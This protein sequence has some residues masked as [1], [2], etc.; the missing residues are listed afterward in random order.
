MSFYNKEKISRNPRVTIEG[1]YE[2]PSIPFLTLCYVLLVEVNVLQLKLN[3][4]E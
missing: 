4:C 1:V 2:N 3:I